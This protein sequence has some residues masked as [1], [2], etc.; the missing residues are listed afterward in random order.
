M[1]LRSKDQIL[2][3]NLEIIQGN[4][5]KLD[6]FFKKYENFFE[7]YRPKAGPI[8]F[9]KLKKRIRVSHFCE[10]LVGKNGVMLL[11]AE[12]YDFDVNHFRIGFARKNLPEALKQFEKY[13]AEF[14]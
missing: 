14:K 11:P 13:L 7:W 5:N 8:A 4:L 3:R 2:K 12:V 9:P 10:D 1:G 6:Q